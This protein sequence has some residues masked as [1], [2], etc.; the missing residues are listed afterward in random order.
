MYTEQKTVQQSVPSHLR[1]SALQRTE[2]IDNT[3]KHS[4]K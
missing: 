1:E 2:T 3:L 4:T